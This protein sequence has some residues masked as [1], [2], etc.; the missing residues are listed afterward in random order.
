MKGLLNRLNNTIREAQA[1]QGLSYTGRKRR[2]FGENGD[3]D[4]KHCWADFL[5]SVKSE[6]RPRL[7]AEYSSLFDASWESL[8]TKSSL[9]GLQGQ[10]GGYTIPP[11]FIPTLLSASYN[12]L[13]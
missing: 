10:T 5:V 3:G 6:N 1:A 4:P 9:S 13:V 11:E 12:A 2:F 7:A 8:Q